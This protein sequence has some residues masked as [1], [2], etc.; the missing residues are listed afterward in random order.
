MPDRGRENYAVLIWAYMAHKLGTDRPTKLIKTAD[1]EN[2][3]VF[4]FSLP[5]PMDFRSYCVFASFGLLLER[6]QLTKVISIH[7][8]ILRTLPHWCAQFAAHTVI[9]A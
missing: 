9:H 7:F 6:F 5:Y 1:F 8:L 4:F 2:S 3:Q